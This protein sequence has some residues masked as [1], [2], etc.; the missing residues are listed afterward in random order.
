MADASSYETVLSAKASA[1]L[2]GLSKAKQRR[3]IGL[4]FK[5]AENPNQIGDYSEPDDT[6]RE[7]QFLWLRDLLIAFWPDHPVR[8]LRIVEIH[9]V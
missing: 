3:L 9:E 2:V 4:L 6:G 5:L 7:I 1:F 8:E